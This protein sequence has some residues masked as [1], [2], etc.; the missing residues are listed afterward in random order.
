MENYACIV[1]DVLFDHKETA[2]IPHTRE[3]WALPAE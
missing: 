3:R 2:D 1:L